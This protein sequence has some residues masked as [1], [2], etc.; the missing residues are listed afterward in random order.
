MITLTIDGKEVTVQPGETILAAANEAGI[1]IPTL[2]YHKSLL[3]I[4]SCRLCLV[5][6]EGYSE[7]MTACNKALDGIVVITIVGEALP[8]EA[9]IS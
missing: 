7:P 1:D 9:G 5:E 4:G 2:C 8:D 3:P 6:V